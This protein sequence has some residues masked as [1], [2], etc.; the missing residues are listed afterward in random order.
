MGANH[1]DFFAGRNFEIPDSGTTFM[2]GTNVKLNIGDIIKPNGDSLL[3]SGRHGGIRGVEPYADDSRARLPRA[4]AVPAPG[5]GRISSGHAR[6]ALS[7]AVRS[8]SVRPTE[9][10]R[11]YLYQVEPISHAE[12]FP[13]IENEV[14][15][16]EGFRVTRILADV[17][18]SHYHDGHWDDGRNV[19]LTEHQSRPQVSNCKECGMG[20]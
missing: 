14:S 16:P 15:S 4:W 10:K 17:P 11:A 2:H 20:V 6:H 5:Y 13:S 9:A 3:Q 19:Y 7:Y 12:H 1:A 18:Q 8:E